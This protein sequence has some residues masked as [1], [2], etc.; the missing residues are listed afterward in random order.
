MEHNG[1]IRF[2]CWIIAVNL[3]RQVWNREGTF[4]ADIFLLRIQKFHRRLLGTFGSVQL[5]HRPY[6]GQIFCISIIVPLSHKVLVFLEIYLLFFW[7]HVVFKSWK[8]T[9]NGYL[10]EFLETSYILQSLSTQL[11]VALWNVIMD[12]LFLGPLFLPI[13]LTWWSEDHIKT[14]LFNLD[15]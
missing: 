6:A 8:N 3:L 14:H 12:G 4:F 7:M 9:I 11:F 2:I 5:L 1:K 10:L 13:S 15:T